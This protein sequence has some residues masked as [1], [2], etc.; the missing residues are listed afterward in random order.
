MTGAARTLTGSS[1]G[2]GPE[3]RITTSNGDISIDKGPVLPLPPLPPTPPK[4]TLAPAAPS[5]AP[6]APKSP[7]EP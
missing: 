7:D 2:G 6:R 5:H 4:V 1:N 3:V